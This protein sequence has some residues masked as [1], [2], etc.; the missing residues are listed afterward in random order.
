MH[1]SAFPEDT[2]MIGP[3]LRDLAAVGLLN[4]GSIRSDEKTSDQ[5]K[6]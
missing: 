3:F 2:T 1:R 4:S 6:N 5:Y